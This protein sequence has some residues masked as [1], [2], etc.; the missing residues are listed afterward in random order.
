MASQSKVLTDVAE[1]TWFDALE[2]RGS[3]GPKAPATREWSIR[4]RTL[5]GGPSDHVDVIDLD[6]GLLAVS[7]VPTR[8]MGLWRGRFADLELG[9]NSPVK[10]PVNPAF[11]NLH[12]RNGLGWLA[13]FNELLCRCGLSSN[14]PPGVDAVDDKAGK[15]TETPLTLHGKIANTPAHR[16]EV[17]AD[18][19]GDGV[20][21]VRGEIDEAAMFGPGL[22][23]VTTYETAPGSNRLTIRDVVRNLS[24][25]PLELQ[26][27]Y[28]TNL[29]PPFLEAGSKL[30]LPV[31]QAA[32]RDP[33]AAEDVKSWQTYREPTVGYAEQCYYAE[34]I[35][36]DH[37]QTVVLLRN[38]AGDRGVSLEYGIR[39]LPCF[40]VWKCTQAEAD[41]YVTGLEP[42]T[43][44]P[45]LKTFERSHGRVITLA[46]QQTYAVQIDLSVHATATE[47]AAVTKRI[48]ELQHRAHP[49]VHETPLAAFSPG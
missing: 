25:R 10:R 9:W 33:R 47:V 11:V 15:R 42:A 49:I 8:G 22:R 21:S 18:S 26:L 36:D 27:L 37:E 12:D 28:H 38:A 39:V 34:L 3:A 7:I 48:T 45:N 44:Y 1:E 2:L 17:I 35:G 14:G 40:T 20:L 6:N 31:R 30:L 41:G 5:R 32:P 4:K 29:G 13:G 16:V 46:P 43:N 24:A 19:A 23:L